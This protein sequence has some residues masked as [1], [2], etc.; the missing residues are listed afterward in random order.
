MRERGKSATNLR[1]PRQIDLGLREIVDAVGAARVVLVEQDSYSRNL[2]DM[3]LDERHQAN[4]DHP[5]AIDSARNA[6]S[7]NGLEVLLHVRTRPRL[8]RR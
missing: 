1:H 3:P 5:D 4:F 2:A 8:R 6:A 7:Q